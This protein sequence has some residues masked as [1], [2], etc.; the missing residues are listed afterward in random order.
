MF[1][2]LAKNDDYTGIETEQKGECVNRLTSLRLEK[3]KTITEIVNLKYSQ[4]INFTLF[5]LPYYNV[6][7][8]P[9]L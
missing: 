7:F 8:E 2:D 9:S 6:I 1:G 4:T 5:S 3:E